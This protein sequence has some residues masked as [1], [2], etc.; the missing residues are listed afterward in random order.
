MVP[1]SKL[2]RKRADDPSKRGS[3]A[4]SSQRRMERFRA[5]PIEIQPV[6]T[7]VDSVGLIESHVEENLRTFKTC[8]N[9]ITETSL[10]L[11]ELAKIFGS[12][13]ISQTA[14]GSIMNELGSQ[15]S[16]S[17]EEIFRSREILELARARAKLEWAREKMGRKEFESEDAHSILQYDN[18]VKGHLDLITP[19]SRWE[20]IISRIDEALSSLKVEQEASIIERYLSLAKEKFP[21]E[22]ESGKAER[23]K[24][25]CQNRLGS[26]SEGWASARRDK[27]GQAGNLE[28]KASQ[29]RDDI[30]EIEVR[31]A[32]GELDQ[33]TFEYKMSALQAS[34]KRVTEEISEIRDYIDDMDMK[35]FRC[36]ELARENP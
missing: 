23:V 21:A 19:V 24:A 13:E 6:L 29:T 22:A 15:L 4:D 17:V 16:T 18:Y 30:R 20:E 11:D 10:G 5:A 34:L 25:V 9:K 35:I 27:I 31:F 28:L 1:P 14:Y 26:I 12:G 3:A 33:R 8:V 32:V 2:S 7:W 36:S